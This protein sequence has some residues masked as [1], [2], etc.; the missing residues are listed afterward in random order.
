MRIL[1]HF[2]PFYSLAPVKT[3][4]REEGMCFLDEAICMCVTRSFAANQE[5]GDLL[6]V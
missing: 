3:A 6:I 5:R 4:S 2:P 1:H